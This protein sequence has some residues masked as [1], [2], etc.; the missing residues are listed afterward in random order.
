MAGGGSSEVD[1]NFI[2]DRVAVFLNLGN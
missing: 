2:N 1:V